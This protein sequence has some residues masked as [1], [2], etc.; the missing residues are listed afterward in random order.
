M[1]KLLTGLSGATALL[2]SY[3]SSSDCCERVNVLVRVGL[4]EPGCLGLSQY[5]GWFIAGTVLLLGAMVGVGL[6]GPGAR[7]DRL[8]LPAVGMG[9][10]AAVCGLL[11][12][13][14][15]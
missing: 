4:A 3:L 14:L 12:F 13:V 7:G 10:V 6:Y 15:P 2:F 1:R 9:V 11:L 8:A 5:R